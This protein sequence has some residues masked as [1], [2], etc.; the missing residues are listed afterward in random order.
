MTSNK[1]TSHSDTALHNKIVRAL[2][3]GATD[4]AISEDPAEKNKGKKSKKAPELLTPEQ[5]L[6]YDTYHKNKD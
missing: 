6:F 5:K 3:L 2:Q 1:K 4:K